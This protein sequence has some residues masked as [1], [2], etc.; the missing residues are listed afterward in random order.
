[1]TDVTSALA[2]YC[3]GRGTDGEYHHVEDAVRVYLHA[4][5][6]GTGWEICDTTNDG[7]SLFSDYDGGPLTEGCECE[8]EVTCK[9]RRDGLAGEYLPN[10]P[11]LLKM[12]ADKLIGA[13]VLADYRRAADAH[14]A[15]EEQLNNMCAKA[16]ES[17]SYAAADDFR[18]H[19][20]TD[21]GRDAL[22]AAQKVLAIF[23]Y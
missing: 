18:H 5:E 12:L 6:D 22:A 21:A 7:D 11:E 20:H 4:N 16:E 3:H 19:D 23:G 13:E 8:D 15:A 10:A 2:K 1:M 17:G 9:K 14:R